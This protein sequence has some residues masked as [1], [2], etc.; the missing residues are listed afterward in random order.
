VPEPR[1]LVNLV[2]VRVAMRA[3]DAGDLAAT[4]GASAIAAQDGRGV[5]ART[6]WLA[7]DALLAR[8]HAWVLGGT[9][10][11]EALALGAAHTAAAAAVGEAAARLAG[12]LRLRRPAI[13]DTAGPYRGARP[14]DSGVVLVSI[15]MATTLP[16]TLGRVTSREVMRD[17]VAGVAE[18][19][20]R[21]RSYAAGY[22]GVMPGH[23]DDALDLAHVQAA[24]PPPILVDLAAGVR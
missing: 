23:P 21:H 10:Y 15:G 3:L 5:E 13:R 24:F 11:G 6:L 8:H 7:A 20:F 9:T 4:L 14:D 22:F 2:V 16:F 17:H 19:A 18:R 1:P 12:S